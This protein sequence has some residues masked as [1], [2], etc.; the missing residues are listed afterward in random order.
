MFWWHILPHSVLLACQD[1]IFHPM[2]DFMVI[3]NG[4]SLLFDFC[5]APGK[6]TDAQKLSLPAEIV[7]VQYVLTV[8]QG[9][10]D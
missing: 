10:S 8:R 5:M 7:R 6:N 4:A 3:T 9:D 1:G 2:Q